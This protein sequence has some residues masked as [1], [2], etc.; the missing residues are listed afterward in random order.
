LKHFI[1]IYDYAP[2]WQQRRAAHRPAH[3]ALANA[4]AARDE[5]QLGGAVPEGG[6]AF[7]LLLFKAATPEVAEAFAESDPYV[8]QGVV[9]AWRVHEWVTVV[10][11]GALTKV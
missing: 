9:T 7:G 10:G 6:P 2:D 8:S 5:L 4:S 3:L 1:L 11:A